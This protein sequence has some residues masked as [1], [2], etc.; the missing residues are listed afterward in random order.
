MVSMLVVE[1]N[2]ITRCRTRILSVE[3]SPL[4]VL[5]GGVAEVA[6][7]AAALVTNR[8]LR[9]LEVQKS[10]WDGASG[11]ASSVWA[12]PLVKASYLRAVPAQPHVTPPARL[13][14]AIIQKQPAAC[15]CLA[16]ADGSQPVRRQ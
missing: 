14:V 15:V 5:T 6:A 12:A 3:G 7:G 13:A 4:T 2:A 16:L 9:F 8:R 1:G 10:R 11:L